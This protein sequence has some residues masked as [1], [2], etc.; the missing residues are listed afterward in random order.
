MFSW[1]TLCDKY[2]TE[3]IYG[4]TPSGALSWQYRK[5]KILEQI[6]ESNADILCLQEIATDAFKDFYSPELAMHDYRG[7]HFP[8][9]RAKTMHEK[10]ANTVDGCA[11]YYKQ[12]KFVMLDKHFFDFA[13]IAIN[14]PDMKNQHDIFNRVM[15]KDQVGVIC[16]FESRGTGARLIIANTHLCWEPTL[17]D[18]KV[19]QTAILMEQVAKLA[20]KYTRFP[21][22]KD[23]KLIVAPTSPDDDEDGATR[24]P[25]PPVLEPAPSQ[26]YRS[27]TEIPLL[28]CGDFN[29][30]SD[31]S[32]YELLS[33]GHVDG[34]HQELTG[35]SYGN[36]TR[37]GIDHPFSLRSAYAPLNGTPDE[38]PF[39]NYTPDFANVIDY[40]WY[41]TNTL[42]VVDL[43][44]PPDAEHLARVPGFPNYHFP[45]DHIQLVADLIIKARK[46]DKKASSGGSG[47]A[48][49]AAGT[50]ADG[51]DYHGGGGPSSRN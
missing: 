48:S 34:R 28:V 27:I 47:G 3:A 13:S 40:I 50:V 26:E 12:S 41:S 46:G 16:F 43:L 7:V 9:T 35:Y 25:P 22:C 49:A 21:P 11:V 5:V 8:K 2:S 31:S 6:I 14:R 29:S 51:A 10:D 33:T 20:D 4:Y 42:E 18:V 1:N 32:V 19:I 44:G 15:P 30:M 24:R 45:A 36:F 39:T 37:D 38:L 23:K 17:A